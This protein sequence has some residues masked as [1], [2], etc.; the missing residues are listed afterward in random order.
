MFKLKYVFNIMQPIGQIRTHKVQGQLDFQYLKNVPKFADEDST[1]Q[2]IINEINRA[3]SEEN[4][5]N[6]KIDTLKLDIQ[7]AFGG[8]FEEIKEVYGN[9]GNVRDA[10]ENVDQLMNVTSQP[11]NNNLQNQILTSRINNIEQLLFNLQK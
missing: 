10:I 3:T 8:T 6:T 11:A 5:L 2:N 1:N 9:L 4:K 7:D